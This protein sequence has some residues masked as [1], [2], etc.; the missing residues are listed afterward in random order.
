MVYL[1]HTTYIIVDLAHHEIFYF[2]IGKG[3]F[4]NSYTMGC[5][6]VLGDNPRTLASRLFYVKVDKHGITSLYHLHMCRP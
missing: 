1:V 5:P 6:P 4:S 3:C 2:K